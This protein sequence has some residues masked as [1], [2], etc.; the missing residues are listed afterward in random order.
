MITLIKRFVLSLLIMFSIYLPCYSLTLEASVEYTVDSARELAF[1]DIDLTI[2]TEDFIKDK[3]DLFHYSN[4]AA[5]K[6]GKY[7]VGIGFSRT[8]IPFYIHKFLIAYGVKYDDKPDKILYY[9]RKGHFIKVEY[10]MSELEN[11]PKKT[12]DYDIN[13]NLIS[14]SFYV[15]KEEVYIYKA[16]GDLIGHWV[17]NTLYNKK[18][19]EM[20]I[21]RKLPPNMAGCL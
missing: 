19:K 1:K 16:N 6:E 7:N 14:V 12:V 18:G 4:I 20:K 10:K 8:L 9:G 2:S 15:S 11:Y 3:Y 13:G 21:K 17:G 5:L